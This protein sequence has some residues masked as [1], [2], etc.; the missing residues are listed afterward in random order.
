V[1]WDKTPASIC[2]IKLFAMWDSLAEGNFK[3]RRRSGWRV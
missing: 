3:P 2:S 1:A